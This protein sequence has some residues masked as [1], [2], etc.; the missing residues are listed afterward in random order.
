M[1]PPLPLPGSSPPPLTLLVD[2][3]SCPLQQMQT[4]RRRKRRRRLGRGKQ[5]VR[6]LLRSSSRSSLV[7]GFFFVGDDCRPVE[8]RGGGA[9][10]VERA[11]SNSPEKVRAMR[12]FR[13]VFI[14]REACHS[15]PLESA[16]FQWSHASCKAE[17]SKTRKSEV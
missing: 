17:S 12:L 9:L 4:R 1:L 5:E 11:P 15:F 10:S 16:S 7:C 14:I 2:C 13:S 6:V 8:A 3:G